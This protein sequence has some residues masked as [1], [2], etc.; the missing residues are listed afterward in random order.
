M[1]KPLGQYNTTILV[2]AVTPTLILVPV[3]KGRGS[4]RNIEYGYLKAL[5]QLEPK[6]LHFTHYGFLQGRLPSVEVSCFLN[7]LL[8]Q[9]LPK[10]LHILN[11]DID[12]RRS[13]E[14]FN[15]MRAALQG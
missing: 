6:C 3:T 1:Q 2:R 7:L 14:V 10:S 12:E 9:L 15:L 4:R 5:H 8:G 13:Q 11:V